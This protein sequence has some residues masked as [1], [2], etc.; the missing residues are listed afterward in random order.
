MNFNKILYIF[1]VHKIDTRTDQQKT[2]DLLEEYLSALAIKK[3]N[4]DV[5]KDIRS[6]LDNLRGIDSSKVK[7]LSSQSIS[8][9]DY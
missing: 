7:S 5:D 6:R 8:V 3:S 9:S 4:E 1:Q 2:D